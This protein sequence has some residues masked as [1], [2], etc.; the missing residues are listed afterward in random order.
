MKRLLF[1]I[2]LAAIGAVTAFAQSYSNPAAY[3]G[4]LDGRGPI[5]I[6]GLPQHPHCMWVFVIG[7]NEPEYPSEIDATPFYV[8]EDGS[9]NLE[10]TAPSTSFHPYVMLYEDSFDVLDTT[11]NCLWALP[12][13]DRYLSVDHDLSANTSYLLAVSHQGRPALPDTMKNGPYHVTISTDGEGEICVGALG[14]CDAE[15]DLD[16]DEPGLFV[17]GDGMFQLSAAQSE[18]LQNLLGWVFRNRFLFRLKNYWAGACESGEMA[19]C[20]GETL[21]YP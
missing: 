8:T 11:R 19:F 9:Y 17:P 2:V 6:N 21:P 14:T 1:M 3:S 7:D 18:S 10:I 13:T 12:A 4:E 5:A 15:A 20:P 16:D